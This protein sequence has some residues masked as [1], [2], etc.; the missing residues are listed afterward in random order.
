MS[1]ASHNFVT[2]RKTRVT[3][4]PA[5]PRLL[6]AAAGW[7][8]RLSSAFFGYILGLSWDRSST[9]TR[10]STRRINLL[11]LAWGTGVR[12]SI[13]H[14]DSHTMRARAWSGSQ[15]LSHGDAVT[16]EQPR[17]W[18]CQRCCWGWAHVCWRM[19]VHGLLH[20]DGWRTH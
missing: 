2:L 11:F 13:H 8:F 16:A 7:R 12:A 1:T 5:T 4:V 9:I 19:C 14:R 20:D 3:C 6:V 18:C 15:S 10:A 17:R